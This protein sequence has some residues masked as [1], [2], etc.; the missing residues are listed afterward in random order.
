MGQTGGVSSGR[1]LPPI[2]ERSMKPGLC[3][4]GLSQVGPLGVPHN[5]KVAGSHPAP[6]AAIADSLCARST[7][8]GCQHPPEIPDHLEQP[9]AGRDHNAVSEAAH[10]LMHARALVRR[11]RVA[12]PINGCAGV[13]AICRALPDSAKA[14]RE[15]LR[16][17]ASFRIS[18]RL[19]ICGL[20]VRFHRGSRSSPS[21]RWI[22]N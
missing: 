5:P 19:I 7:A 15:I 6:A 21:A 16:K 17:S 22:S 3:V 18:E 11:H 20:M 4:V 14:P 13:A 10:R 9:V 8:G 2:Q 1:R 12:A